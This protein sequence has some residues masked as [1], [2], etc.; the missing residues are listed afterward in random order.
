[1]ADKHTGKNRKSVIK[2]TSDLMD[3]RVFHR[4]RKNIRNPC[5]VRNGGCSHI[6]LLKK[7]EYACACGIGVKLN[8]DGRTCKD[9]PSNYILF[10]HR[11]DIRQVSLDFIE[12]YLFDV[13]L[14]LPQISNVYTLD[15]D[16]HTGKTSFFYK[17]HNIN[18]VVYLQGTY[19]G[20]IIWKM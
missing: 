15:V 4:K 3:I 19:I 1:M 10:A 20:Q 12:G 16:L 6:C 8:E 2:D 9:L 13:V 14:P 18:S 17:L 11:T 5:A 7:Q